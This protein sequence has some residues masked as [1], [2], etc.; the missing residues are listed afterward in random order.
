MARVVCNWA[1]SRFVMCYFFPR[2][3]ATHLLQVH[4]NKLA[5][6][7]WTYPTLAHNDIDYRLLLGTSSYENIKGNNGKEIVATLCR[8]CGYLPISLS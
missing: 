2:T 8:L 7:C 4:T 6:V 5:T 3:Q 1:A